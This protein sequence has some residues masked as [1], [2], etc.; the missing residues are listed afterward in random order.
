MNGE[1]G[2]GQMRIR[3][4]S[5]RSTQMHADQEKEEKR[6]RHVAPSG[7]RGGGGGEEGRRGWS[8]EAHCT[9]SGDV[10]GD[11]TLSLRSGL[12]LRTRIIERYE[13]APARCRGHRVESSRSIKRSAACAHCPSFFSSSGIASGQG[14]PASFSSASI[15]AA[16]SASFPPGCRPLCRTLPEGSTIAT[17]GM[18]RTP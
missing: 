16:L 11:R 2:R 13:K 14:R 18:P 9:S 8:S 17:C 10:G 6:Q 4:K 3:K 5:R 15:F 7:R 12:S 1:N